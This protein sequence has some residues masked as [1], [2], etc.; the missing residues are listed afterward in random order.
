MSNLIISSPQHRLVG[1]I[2]QQVNIPK[3]DVLEIGKCTHGG[4]K[5]QK[6]EI[7]KLL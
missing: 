1:Y 7:N 2:G 3:V 5:P 6:V 4:A